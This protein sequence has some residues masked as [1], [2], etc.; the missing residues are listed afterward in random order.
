MLNL[1]CIRQAFIAVL[2][3]VM[4]PLSAQAELFE[5]TLKNGLRVIVLED[6]RANVV[7]QQ[8]WYRVGSAD[9]SL[10]KT[11]VSHLLEHLMFKATTKLTAGE[12]S[13]TIHRLGGRENALSN[14]F[15]TL[16]YQI[17]AAENLQTIM[18]MEADRMNGL[19][20]TQ[21]EFD[22]EL[23]IVQE[24]RLSRVDDKPKAQLYEKLLA[25][26]FPDCYQSHPVTGYTEDLKHLKLQDVK[27]WYKR[28]YRANNAT[29]IIAGNIKH[30]T[31][32][33]LAIEFFNQKTRYGVDEAAVLI[34]KKSGC[35]KDGDKRL[36]QYWDKDDNSLSSL[37]VL[38][39]KLDQWEPKKLANEA[40]ALEVLA[41]ILGGGESARLRRNL[42]VNQAIATKTG[43]RYRLYS[44]G[45]PLFLISA[46]PAEGVSLMQLEAAIMSEIK[47]IATNGIDEQELNR[48]K[49]QV[50]AEH[51]FSQDSVFKRAMNIGRIDIAGL[52]STTDKAYLMRINNITV[53]DV[54]SAAKKHLT[55]DN[56]FLGSLEANKDE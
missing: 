41:Y 46:V 45:H 9:E 40:Y 1:F 54:K 55:K 25:N 6:Q 7:V 28:W 53:A 32:F 27:D 36:K 2:L 19:I 5:K 43:L 50:Q 8:L 34:A 39:Y 16:Y 3:L 10:G 29:L 49:V 11:G 21:K 47:K 48:V 13:K 38:A 44:Q 14:T 24:E 15:Y 35:Y 17:V 26:V 51:I 33:N 37:L 52:D 12:F 23:N 4:M 31:V 18:Q 42:E 22:Q 30:Q 20:F 56:L